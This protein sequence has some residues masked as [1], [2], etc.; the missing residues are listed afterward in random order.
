MLWKPRIVEQGRI[1]RA[2]L[3]KD[4]TDIEIADAWIFA[5]ANCEVLV[6]SSVALR[7]AVRDVA[8]QNPEQENVRFRK[9]IL[10]IGNDCVN[11]SLCFLGALVV[12]P[13]IIGSDQQIQQLSDGVRRPRHDSNAKEGG[14][15]CRR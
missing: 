2:V 6:D 9:A 10:K 14:P 15:S 12:M 8:R 1:K 5:I 4:R 7:L 3:I 11:T 13:G